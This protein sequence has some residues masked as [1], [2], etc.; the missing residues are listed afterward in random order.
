VV[1]YIINQAKELYEKNPSLTIANDKD[2]LM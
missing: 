2:V 1:N